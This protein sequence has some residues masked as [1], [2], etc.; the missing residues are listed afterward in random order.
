LPFIIPG[1][2]GNAFP[3]DREIKA[4]AQLQLA[5]SFSFVY[6]LNYIN[7]GLHRVKNDKNVP[8]KKVPSR[9]NLNL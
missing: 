4:E 2:Q 3:R 5:S 8:K 9:R 6:T 1:P 7:N